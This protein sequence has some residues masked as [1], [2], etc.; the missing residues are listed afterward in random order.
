M[1]ITSSSSLAWSL[2]SSKA[3]EK[4]QGGGFH[5][6]RRF[7][8]CAGRP[9]V[10]GP[11]LLFLRLQGGSFP[12]THFGSS[13][14]AMAGDGGVDAKMTLAGACFA[15]WGS[16]TSLVSLLRLSCDADTDDDVLLLLLL[17]SFRDHGDLREGLEG[18]QGDQPPTG[19]RRWCDEKAAGWMVHHPHR[20]K[21]RWFNKNVWGSW[22]MA[23]RLAKLQ[24]EAWLSKGK[25]A[26]GK[27]AA[28][29]SPAKPAA[30]SPAKAAAKSPGK[31]AAADNR[32]KGFTIHTRFISLQGDGEGAGELRPTKLS[33]AP[34]CPRKKSDSAAT[35]AK[36]AAAVDSSGGP[37]GGQP[38]PAQRPRFQWG[39]SALHVGEGPGPA[40]PSRF[41]GG[42]DVKLELKV[43]TVD[44]RPQ[45]RILQI[46]LRGELPEA[47]TCVRVFAKRLAPGAD[48]PVQRRGRQML[49]IDAE[50]PVARAKA[51]PRAPS[52]LLGRA[53]LS[54]KG[55]LRLLE[56]GAEI[57]GEMSL[58]QVGLQ[59]GDRLMLY[60]RPAAVA[61]TQHAFAAI[62]GDGSV[63]TWGN[64]EFGGDCSEVQEKLRNVQCIQ[65][66][67]A[68]FAAL[69]ADGSVVAWGR[70]KGGIDKGSAVECIQS[71][72]TAFAALH[73]DGSLDVWG[74]F[75]GAGALA[76]FRG[77]LCAFADVSC[78]QSNGATFAA[79]LRDGS[80]RTLGDFAS[81][82]DISDVQTH[83]HGVRHLQSTGT[84]FAAILETGAVVAWGKAW[85]GGDCREV[86]EQ[87]RAVEAIQSTGSA[88]AAI[89]ADGR[90]VTWGFSAEGGDSRS[91]SEQLRDVRSIQATR[92]AFAAIRGDGSV[93]SWGDL[94]C[95]GDS[96]AVA[97]KLRRVERIQ[98]TDSAFAAVCQDGSVVTWGFPAA[99][100][101]S[102]EVQERLRGVEQIQ[103]TRFAFAALLSDASVVSWGSPRDG[104]DS[105]AVASQLRG[106]HQIQASSK[107]FAALRHDGSVVTW[108]SQR[109]VTWEM[110]RV[111]KQGYAVVRNVFS[112]AECLCQ[113]LGA[114]WVLWE[115]RLL[116]RRR[117]VERGIYADRPHH[118]SWDGFTFG[119]PV[120]K[121]GKRSEWDHT[122]QVL[123]GGESTGCTW[124]Q[125]VVALNAL[126]PEVGA[127]FECWPGT[128]G[129]GFRRQRVPV[130]RGDVILWDSRLV[131]QA[132]DCRRTSVG[133]AA[134][135]FSLGLREFTP[136]AVLKKRREAFQ[137]GGVAVT[138]NHKAEGFEPFKKSRFTASVLAAHSTQPVRC[139]RSKSSSKPA[140]RSFSSVSG[141]MAVQ[142][143]SLFNGRELRRMRRHIREAPV[144]VAE[145]AAA[146][147]VADLL[148]PA[149]EA[150]AAQAKAAMADEATSRHC[151]QALREP[152]FEPHRRSGQPREQQPSARKAPVEE[153]EAEQRLDAGPV[154]PRDEK[155][156]RK[157][158]KAR[159]A[160]VPAEE[161]TEE[162]VREEVE[163]P[164]AEDDGAGIGNDPLEDA[165]QQKKRQEEKAAEENEPPHR[166]LAGL[167]RVSSPQEIGKQLDYVQRQIQEAPA[168]IE[169]AEDL[170]R[171]GAANPDGLNS[172][173][174]MRKNLQ[175][176]IRERTY[177]L[178]RYCS[179]RSKGGGRN[180][181][182]DHELHWVV[183]MFS[184]TSKKDQETAQAVKRSTW[185][186]SDGSVRRGPLC[187]R[188]C[189]NAATC[190]GGAG[191]SVYI[192]ACKTFGEGSEKFCRHI[193]ERGPFLQQSKF[194]P[195]NDLLRQF[196][197]G[198]PA[199]Y[200]L[201]ELAGGRKC[202]R[203]RAW[204]EVAKVPELQPDF[205]GP[206][207]LPKPAWE[208]SEE[209]G[210]ASD[211]DKDQPL[212]GVKARRN[213]RRHQEVQ[214][215]PAMPAHLREHRL[216]WQMDAWLDQQHGL[217]PWR[218][219]E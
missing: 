77:V 23:Y 54:T 136:E 210:E 11:F 53:A 142:A 179:W 218:P 137:A 48:A 17:R 162:V 112:E 80:V 217:H 160:R 92:S 84:A 109:Q 32:G 70:E 124:I 7:D 185:F 97:E 40:A 178:D 204:A 208:E 73:N 79:L 187:H 212:P 115:E 76:N 47:S 83:L 105:S 156:T 168:W 153:D 147:V 58:S 72:E 93:V 55:R 150:A 88:F 65:A 176:R 21:T 219:Q 165:I 203:L 214:D 63:V 51:V 128:Q 151:L 99:G 132:P 183:A 117:L 197:D 199:D 1:S 27:A 205:I 131:H 78:V 171:R 186:N 169:R 9:E 87:L 180:S 24:R 114:G 6:L 28:T 69:L 144:A 177:A 26:A 91:V 213:A 104:G 159:K 46:E 193:L 145:L 195:L 38:Q 36:A 98:S 133:R 64:P 119:R 29:A 138:L 59:T 110:M 134:A 13:A 12:F 118:A 19:V 33:P 122:D 198:V 68:A 200:P 25:A 2:K 16:V 191:C 101:D 35:M 31:P 207:D 75:K 61:A 56:S 81:G 184:R 123:I 190:N 113:L 152:A 85:C 192:D 18:T 5:V 146:V 201:P 116:F 50:P 196:P 60:T 216:K 44:S 188:G 202:E 211:S 170:E 111:V 126:D 96:R 41:D 20:Q 157:A 37:G 161:E 67:D 164:S 135:Y 143:A 121:L 175:A 189:A 215:L 149:G 206:V 107:A 4:D 57:E 86:E 100:G 125:G 209:E 10:E 90:V 15:A 127:A 42:L 163:L 148:P 66:T 108:G 106:V 3:S 102:S 139:S 172:S 49:R 22:H 8:P 129:K 167:L 158:K 141:K 94:R 154:L 120:S 130:G 34:A 74:V 89:L 181:F 52:G 166:A 71:T 95:G 174:Q 155:P 103:A 39:K 14:A 194:S 43:P 173:K 140:F 45:P 182:P 82:A 30:K 62:Q